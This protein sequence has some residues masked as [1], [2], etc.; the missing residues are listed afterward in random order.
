MRIGKR[1][2]IRKSIT[3]INRA[4]T[5]IT[6]ADGGSASVKRKRKQTRAIDIFVR[7]LKNPAQLPM[8]H[9]KLDAIAFEDNP[10][11]HRFAR[12]RIAKRHCH[13]R[14]PYVEAPQSANT[15]DAFERSLEATT[16]AA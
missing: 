9:P 4:K 5:I 16:A 6:F 12:G 11:W 3:A 15:V 1:I 10:Y 13:K 8:S 2:R 7:D 14:G